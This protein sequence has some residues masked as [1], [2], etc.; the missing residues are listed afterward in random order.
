[1]SSTIALAFEE[2]FYGSGMWLGLLL[3]LSIIIALA[4]KNKYASVL[5]IPITLFLGIDYITNAETTSH[6]WGAL[7]MFFTTVLVM[8]QLARKR[9][10]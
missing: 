10:I 6:Y 7:I 5:T 3:L 1:M 9:N 4:L 2:L 8:F